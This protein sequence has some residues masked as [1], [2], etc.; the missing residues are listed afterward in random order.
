[1][2][3]CGTQKTAFTL[4]ELLVVIAIIAILAA[5]L[6]PALYRAKV[7]A[8]TVVCEGNLHQWGLALQ[9][10]LDDYDAY[11]LAAGRTE[12]A[13]LWVAKLVPYLPSG[14]QTNRLGQWVGAKGVFLCPS[15]VHLGGAMPTN[16]IAWGT[17]DE[18]IR[19]FATSYGY[20]DDGFDTHLGLGNQP[21]PSPGHPVPVRE[22]DVVCPSAMLAIGDGGIYTAG[23]L[24]GDGASLSSSHHVNVAIDLLSMFTDNLYF[25][26]VDSRLPSAQFVQR[27]HAGRWNFLFCDGHVGSLPTEDVW[28]YKSNTVLERWNRDHLPHPE[29]AHPHIN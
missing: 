15:Y 28:N 14:G 23:A 6:L 22:A 26:E 18:P 13:E 17:Q 4:I 29:D 24:P 8:N 9:M 19:L 5:L 2:R 12:D 7:E 25:C 1:M 3:K 21:H 20:N 16:G 11:P 10:Y 27:R